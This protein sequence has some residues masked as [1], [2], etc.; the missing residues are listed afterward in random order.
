MGEDMAKLIDT[1]PEYFGEQKVWKDFGKNLPQNWIIYNNRSV[2]GREYDFCVM[3]QEL[4]LFIVEVKGWNPN[5]VLAVVNKNTIFMANQANPEDSPRGQAR[6]YRFALLNKIRKEMGMNPLVMSFVCYPF[7]SREMY[8]EKALNIVSEENETIFMEDLNDPTLL[9]SKFINRYEIDK[10]AKHESLDAKKYALLRHYFEPQFNLKE[11]VDNLNPGYSR[12]RT[13]YSDVSDEILDEIIKEYFKG[14]K[15]IVFVDSSKIMLTMINKIEDSFNERNICSVKSNLA[16]GKTTYSSKNE[17]NYYSIFNFEIYVVNNLKDF[18]DEEIVVEEGECSKKVKE[19]LEK[20]SAVSSFNFQQYEIE[21]A[22]IDKNILVTAGAGTG[23]T[24]SMVSRIAYLC[25]KNTDSVV[26]ISSDIAM[27]TFTNDAAENMNKRIKQMFMNYFVLTANEKYMHLIEDMSQMKI[28]TIHKFAISLLKKDCMRLGLGY[29]CQIS[30]ETYNRKKIYH[31]NLN[32]YI[33]RKTE[34]NPQ[35]KYQLVMPNYELEELLIQFSNKLYNMSVDIKDIDIGDIGTSIENIPYFNELIERVV[36]RS[37]KE[38]SDIVKES[39]L[40]SLNDC[41][42]QIHNLIK[43][44]VLT[45]QGNNYKY[46]FVDEFQDTDDVQIEIITQLKQIFGKQCRLFIVGDLKQSIYRFR[47][48]SLSAFEKVLNTDDIGEWGKYSLNRNYRTDRRLL[49]EFDKVFSF[50][51]D[52]KVLPYQAENDCLTSQIEKQ[53]ESNKLVR[54]IDIDR[55][56]LKEFYKSFFDE[57]KNQINEIE[58]LSRTE[59]LNSDEQTIAI[60]VRYNYQVKAIVDEA[61]KAGIPVKVS[62]GG[63]LYKLPSTMDLYKL[64]MALTHPNNNIYLVN[65]LQS[66]YVDLDLNIARISGL[67][68]EEKTCELIRVLDEYFMLYMGKTWNQIIAEFETRPV[69]VVLR[70]I[71]EA[72]KPWTHFKAFGIQKSY[73]ENYE[74]LI[75]HILSRYSREYL[76]INMVYEFLK[77]NITTYQTEAA[78]ESVTNSTE[79][80]IICTTIHK[81]KGLEYGTVMIPFT[82]DDISNINSGKLNVNILDKKIEYGISLN[83]QGMSLSGGFNQE[84]EIKEK[85][86]EESRILYVAMTRAIRNLV[87]FE[88]KDVKEESWAYYMEEME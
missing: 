62:S 86:C 87:W 81:S 51:G 35:F 7:I 73:K 38:Y 78:R 29:D 67:S 50:M 54:K 20:L 82:Y 75:E 53:Y 13:L 26:D 36:I 22:P 34:E 43:N 14:I 33:E 59:K 69:L 44:K 76:T 68:E 60:L 85:V 49:E 27:I 37:E 66:K 46:I 28:S 12:L 84:R 61:N 63:D 64:V 65:L 83:K 70:D 15:E 4:G 30:S 56:D 23:K 19:V 5:N 6:G 48:A 42:I 55:R 74:C 24:Y 16:I 31:K 58:I 8:R 2:N 71:Y 77:I 45:K 40:L 47:G 1:E 3:A 39:N 21:H 52:K 25:N 79:V 88:D 17:N 80:Q 18:I 72:V 32:E 10:T 9:Y 41:M 11:E 57:V